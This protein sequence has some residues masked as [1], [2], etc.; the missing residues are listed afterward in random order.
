MIITMQGNWTVAVKSKSAAFPHQFVIAGAVFGN[1]VYP[2]TTGTSVFVV[3]SQW[4][5]AIQ[6]NPGSG[7]QL[8]ETQLKFPQQIGGNYVF[9]IYSNDA[10]ADSDFNDLILSCSA[11]RTINDFILYGSV[12][13]YNCRCV[14]NPCRPLVVIESWPSLVEAL[15]NPKLKEIIKKLYPERIPD[16]LVDPNPPDSVL[17]KPIVI[18]LHNEM[19]QPN[20]VL[21]YQRNE[22]AARLADTKEKVKAK[23]AEESPLVVSNFNLIST[24]K[25]RSFAAQNVL[26]YD[27]V[28][29]ASALDHLIFPCKKSPLTNY[30]LTFEEYDRTAAELAGGAYTGT[31]HRRLLGDTI[32]DMFGNYIFRFHFD[33]TFPGIEDSTDIA[34]G[35]DI[36]VVAYPD[37]IVKITANSPLNVL[38]ESAPYFNI[39]NL[40]RI[41][42][43]IPDCNLPE[44][45][46]CFNGNLVGS[47]GNVFIGGNQNSSASFAASALNRHGYN[48]FLDN[49]GKITVH[50][51][52]AGFN[53]EC[54]AWGGTIDMKG[55]MYDVSKTPAQNKIKWYTIR[56]RRA[57]TSGWE[58]VSQN[59][60][61]PRF[62]KRHLPNYTGDD[63]GSF[64]QM[65]KVDG[66]SAIEVPAY[67]N[68]QREIHVD[69]IDWEFSN[70]DRYMR[71]N[72][73]LY[74]LLSG[75]RT[76]GTFYVRVDGYD[77]AG[78]LVPNGTDM[79]A[80]YIHN[81]ELE[82]QM[83]GPVLADPSIVKVP[84]GL[85]RLTEAQEN[86]PMELTFRA[87]D[88]Y[89][90]VDYFT[91]TTGRCPGGTIGLD[92]E[93]N[94]P[95]SDLSAGDTVLSAGSAS[96]NT[97]AAGCPGYTGT[98]QEFA[99]GGLIAVALTP[100][101]ATE[102]WI[103]TGEYY[104]VY[105]FALR[106]RKR[107]TNGYNSGV[108]GEYQRNSSIALERYT[109]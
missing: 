61:H 82:F 71:L 83:T 81:L 103:K 10:G 64:P 12:S 14:F 4:T 100:A 73:H 1:G 29:V 69:G 2:G 94:P 92:V 43:C 62:S 77:S 17:F 49:D 99:S 33:M 84:C 50:S 39:P 51:S 7:F 24:E 20:T 93:P 68:I 52:L 13:K 55:C 8:S 74:D 90:F 88:P 97:H 28:A 21:T 44:N 56:I 6:N 108:S 19:T 80:L 35:E 60:K 57:G 47:L 98:L 106:A 107:V 3:G 76:P 37:V 87:N 66:G 15:K 70:S 105:S 41:N 96:A 30:T 9:D 101:D 58:F 104:T 11:P 79:V 27:R 32:T 42:L 59:Y 102:G 75:V 23:K 109:P 54:A 26:A 22:N 40:R 78:N 85:Y 38:Y 65:L 25:S 34:A 45:S 89:G 67:K 63:V 53:V 91:L 95:L 86:T 5:I 36:N 48:N 16:E 46:A 72:T 18:D 31:G